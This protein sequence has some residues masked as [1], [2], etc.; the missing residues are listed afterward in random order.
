MLNYSEQD[1]W[2]EIEFY[3]L[4]K[5]TLRENNNSAFV[6]TLIE[7]ICELYD[8]N[9]TIIK[10]LLNMVIQGRSMLAPTKDELCVLW[11]K[12]DRSMRGLYNYARVHPNTYRKHIKQLDENYMP[13]LRHHQTSEVRKF[14]ETTRK[15]AEMW[16]QYA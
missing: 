10:S 5:K 12:Q 16:G 15:L 7:A 2:L 1:R 9:T 11:H 6:Y 13:K 14:M 3:F 4:L 8:I